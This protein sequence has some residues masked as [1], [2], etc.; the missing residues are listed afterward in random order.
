VQLTVR[1]IMIA[2]A[3]LAIFFGIYMHAVRES[4]R[5]SIGFVGKD[6]YHWSRRMTDKEIAEHD[7]TLVKSAIKKLEDSEL[8][9]QP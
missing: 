7:W 8:E 4:C 6:G 3:A 9:G 1:R 5:P 2:I